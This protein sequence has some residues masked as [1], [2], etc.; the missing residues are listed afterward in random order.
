MD[1][2]GIAGFILS[3]ISLGFATFIYLKHDKK[4]QVT[5]ATNK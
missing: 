2:L 5:G 3:I 1:Y 4:N